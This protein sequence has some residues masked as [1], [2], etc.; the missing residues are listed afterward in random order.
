MKL[1]CPISDLTYHTLTGYG[2]GKAIHPALTQDF[3]YLLNNLPSY[4]S[5]RIGFSPQ[6]VAKAAGIQ[7]KNLEETQF[8][9]FPN[10]DLYLYKLAWLTQ[11][12]SIT[13]RHPINRKIAEPILTGLIEQLIKVVTSAQRWPHAIY[14]TIIIDKATCDLK[15][16]K[17][18]LE[19]IQ[20]VTAE[21]TKN[22]RDLSRGAKLSRIE[23]SLERIITSQIKGQRTRAAR[24]LAEWASLA[25]EFPESKTIWPDGVTESSLSV[26]WQTII[27][28]SFAETTNDLLAL[29]IPVADIEELIETCEDSIPHGSTSAHEL[30]KSLRAAKKVIEEM[31]SNPIKLLTKE[32]E[33]TAR[34]ATRAKP[35]RSQFS[36]QLAYVK[37]IVK[38]QQEAL[39]VRYNS[40]EL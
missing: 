8:T 3:K 38:W 34:K 4:F 35:T 27:Q 16:L 17:H 11:L 37:A 10:D 31:T 36:S 23:S 14:P 12:P 29:N 19:A 13:F 15:A 30:M 22:S 6:T 1:I 21:A 25:G 20:D 39:E 18:W 33:V 28:H 26:Y 2:T 5:G 40:L 7:T 24:V 32:A 9:G